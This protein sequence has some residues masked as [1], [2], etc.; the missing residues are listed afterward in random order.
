MTKFHTYKYL[1]IFIAACY[2]NSS[3]KLN[4]LND[5]NKS[6]E[7]SKNKSSS[8]EK[9]KKTKVEEKIIV[10][11]NKTS[12]DADYYKENKTVIPLD[13]IKNSGAR[14]LQDILQT[15]SQV[16]TGLD[17]RGTIDIRGQG[18]DKSRQTVSIFVDGVSTNVLDVFH[19]WPGYNIIPSQAIDSIDILAGSGSVI[20]GNGTQGGSIHIKTP[21]TSTKFSPLNFLSFGVGSFNTQNVAMYLGKTFFDNKLLLQFGASYD[22]SKAYLRGESSKIRYIS[23]YSKYK[24]TDNNIIGLM[25]SDYSEDGKYAGF[26]QEK[27]ITTDWRAS[28]NLYPR[29][30]VNKIYNFIYQGSFDKLSVDEQFYVLE[31]SWLKRELKNP[32]TKKTTNTSFANAIKGNKIKFKYNYGNSSTNTDNYLLIGNDWLYTTQHITVNATNQYDYSKE[33]LAFF[34]LNKVFILANTYLI[35]GFRY[36]LDHWGKN[37]PAAT[38]G[39]L[40]KIYKNYNNTIESTAYEVLLG[41]NINK[42]INIY[43]KQET[44]FTS[45]DGMYVTDQIGTIY[46]N[47]N[48][49]NETFVTNEIGTKISIPSSKT[50]FKVALFDTTTKNE[51][52]RLYTKNLEGKS[53]SLALNLRET[54]RK[55]V[56]FSFEQDIFTKINLF[57]SGTYSYNKTLSAN[58]SQLYEKESILGINQI[59][60]QVKKYNQ[61]VGKWLAKVPKWNLLFGYK[62]NIT[63]NLS[64]KNTYKYIS[65]YIG[66]KTTSSD[67]EYIYVNGYLVSDL[68]LSYLINKWSLTIGVKNLFDERYYSSFQ[69]GNSGVLT[70]GMERNFYFAIKY[71]L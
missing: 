43:A 69:G 45:P 71:D 13:V 61:E 8:I 22:T 44:G 51:L 39:A 48:V 12:D 37:S 62:I 52:T 27:N 54:N 10:T 18:Q 7:M 25:Y 70:V 55:G 57:F 3:S 35:T 20:Y 11:A 21:F 38:S 56:E 60:N 14:S 6:L 9:A 1:Y 5:I 36:N 26:I 41:H 16:V 67:R 28:S 47:N 15:T 23:F 33:T 53:V 68:D 19:Y 24:I 63:D 32:T 65:S 34:A 59:N 29:D 49:N 40:N 46:Y 31:G 4:A 64:L 50:S 17:F 42:N 30:R 58:Y 66:T 2:F